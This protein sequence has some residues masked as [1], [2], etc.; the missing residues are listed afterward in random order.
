[1]LKRRLSVA[2][3][4]VLL[5]L[6]PVAARAS[7]SVELCVKHA[8]QDPDAAFAE[9]DA[10]AAAGGGDKAKLC[11]AF[12]Q[13]HRG[14]FPA[15]GDAFSR[16][17]SARAV[18][19]KKHAVSL[20][21]QAALAFMRAGLHDRAESEYAAALKLEPQDPD[22]WLDRATERASVERFWDALADIDKALVLMP[23]MSE[24]VRLRGQI[25][26][27]LGLASKARADL[28]KA[29]LMERDAAARRAPAKGP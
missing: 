2:A 23:E 18:K 21:T 28:E 25:W 16:L 10:W 7:E 29:E 11:R 17:A 9:A 27:K 20:H 22:I 3:L 24:T 19:D 1:M 15:A 12:A 6:A 13:F 14:D 4:A 8:E 26:M 5:S